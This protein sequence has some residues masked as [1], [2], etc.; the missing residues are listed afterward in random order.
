MER[1]S[2]HTNH[3]GKEEN[4]KE[5][6][7]DDFSQPAGRDQGGGKIDGVRVGAED[8]DKWLSRHGAATDQDQ[9]EPTVND[10]E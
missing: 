5:G 1:V 7:H 2:R 10:Y 9:I 6:K 4:G 8:N 3:N